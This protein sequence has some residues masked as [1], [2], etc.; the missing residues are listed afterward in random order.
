MAVYS[1]SLDDPRRIRLVEQL[2]GW[3]PRGE[4]RQLQIVLKSLDSARY[5]ALL[6]D[7]RRFLDEAHPKRTSLARAALPIGD[8]SQV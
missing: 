3:F 4:G 2:R 8:V 1:G 5:R 6:D 7:W